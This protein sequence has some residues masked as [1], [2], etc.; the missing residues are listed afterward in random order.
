MRRLADKV[1]HAETGTT[2][3]HMTGSSK[4][5]KCINSTSGLMIGVNMNTLNE[6]TM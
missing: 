4:P 2:S 3:V 6:K 1:G 5:E